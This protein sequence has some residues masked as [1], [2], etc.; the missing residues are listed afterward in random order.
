MRRPQVR[1]LPG[2]AVVLATNLTLIPVAES[3]FVDIT[4]LYGIASGD[5][6][7]YNAGFIDFDGDGDVDILVNNHWQNQDFYDNVGTPPMVVTS[8]F[9]RT[10]EPDRHD[11]LWGDFNK[12]GTPD[13]YLIHG[14]TQDNELFWNRGG[15]ILEEGG[16]AAGVDDTEGRGRECTLLDA[17]NDGNLD[18][19][20]ANDFRA[21][22]PRPSV[23]LI[24]NGDET[25]SRFPNSQ[26]F[27]MARLHCASGDVDGDG[28]PD[29]ITTNPPF[30]PGELYRN[31]GAFNF[32]DATSTFFPGITDP[33]KQANGLTF[34]DY[35]N[36][37]DLDLLTCSGNR[38]M[39]DYAVIEGAGVKYN[40]EA[41]AGE[42]KIASFETDG[43]EV[44]LFAQ[45]SDWQ[46]VTCWYG[47]GDS[48][49]TTFPITLT[50]A[51]IDGEPPSFA[52]GAQGVFLWRVAGSGVDT[53]H[54]AVGGPGSGTLIVGGHAQTDG[55][56]VSQWT[57]A[58]DAR[59]G[60]SLADF[61][62]RMYRND[63]GVYTEVTSVAFPPA[64]NGSDENSLTAAWGDYDN[65][66]WVDVYVVNC[67]NVEIGNQPNYLFRNNGDGTFEDVTAL[68][69]LA[70]STAGM[71]D[72]A[73]WGDITGD[74]FLDLYVDNG[75]EHPPF[76]VGPRQLFENDNA[77]N[78]NH[79]MKLDLRGLESNGTGYGTRVRAVTDTQVIWRHQL[80]ESDN[81]FSAGP[82]LHFG[83]GTDAQI[84]TLDVYWPS[85]QHDRHFQVNAD[86]GYWALEGKP[87]RTQ[88]LPHFIVLRQP[89]ETGMSEGEE[90]T[91]NVAVDNFGGL[92]CIWSVSY[93]D[94]QG[95]PISWLSMAADSG[96]IWPGGTEPM[97]AI[98]NTTGLDDGAYCGRAIFNSTS[99]Q[100]PDT[101]VAFLT[102]TDSP[103]D[104][105][106]TTGLP[107]AFALSGSRPNPARR[108]AEVTLA[109][110]RPA[111]ARVEVYSI[112][113][114]RVQTLADGEYPAGFH[115]LRWD[116]RDQGGRK[117]AAG[118]YFVKAVAGDSQQVQ[119]I[120]VLE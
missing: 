86:Q 45:K 33:L 59:P 111:V 78:G 75:A 99:F 11:M 18:I 93:E 60:F 64:V 63:G 55:S 81:C 119:K 68:T 16:V 89:I 34:N 117:V 100:G 5:S 77:G 66:G 6:M 7:S 102:V 15:G 26:D 108:A 47:S 83:L 61:T 4:N 115:D 50:M 48:L 56:V 87:L 74:G 57:T 112:A 3:A 20:V 58:Y 30:Q 92:A 2:F 90:R 38:A 42:M 72:G 14:R 106:T 19:F 103:V 36:D 44:T 37:G 107:T 49:T 67:G 8:Q 98:I 120:V 54:V 21:G 40:A 31:D 51:Q 105:P 88:T 17:D 9:Y 70:G 10:D 96:G 101:L 69:G 22:F 12:D 28:D 84:D 91:F 85:G 29:L 39:W 116:L 43:T 41:E 76:G 80:G 1:L 25:F 82:T 62:N 23:L 35:D 94:C 104:A 109:L 65:D 113:G 73:A 52:G 27:S 46:P 97:T 95:N 71:G 114:R 110:P 53:V 118:T 24:N 32:N 79:W 13:N